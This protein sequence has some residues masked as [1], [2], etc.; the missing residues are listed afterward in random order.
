M[1]EPEGPTRTAQT[2]AEN[3]AQGNNVD[4]FLVLVVPAEKFNMGRIMITANAERA[5]T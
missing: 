3:S 4:G 5:M 1:P 2:P